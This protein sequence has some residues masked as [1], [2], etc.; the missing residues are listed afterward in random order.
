MSERSVAPLTPGS[1]PAAARSDTVATIFSAPTLGGNSVTMIWRGRRLG[2]ASMRERTRIL[3]V[4][5]S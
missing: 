2:S 1:R 3:P 4:P 5:V